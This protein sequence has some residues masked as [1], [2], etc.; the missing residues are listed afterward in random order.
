MTLAKTTRPST[1]GVLPRPRVFRLLDRAR[2]SPV[3]WISGPPGAGKTSAVAS[4]VKARRLP[5]LWYQLETGDGDV[6]SFFYY[7]RQ[8]A[9]AGPRGRAATLPLLT[10]EYLGGLESF[11]RRFFRELFARYR[12]PFVI[13]F[14][15]YQD[16]APSSQLHDVIREALG[17]IPPGGHVALISRG[18][19]PPTL[20]RLRAG[21]K[22]AL[23]G[24]P[25]LRLTEAEARRLVRTVAPAAAGAGFSALYDA[26]GGWAAGLVLMLEEQRGVS[27]A[28]GAASVASHEAIF[29]YFAGEIF[30]GAPVETREILLQTALLPRLTAAMAE[31]L[32]GR[33]AA[34]RVLAELSRQNYFTQ[35]HDGPEPVYQYHPLFREFLLRRAQVSLVATRRSEI[36][37]HGAALL[38]AAGQVEDAVAVL[39]DAREWDG[40]AALIEKEAPALVA[41][42]RGRTLQAWVDALPADLVQRRGWL[43]YWRGVCWFPFSPGASRAEFERALMH[44]WTQ[45][46]ATGTFLAWAAIVESFV[47]EQQDYHPLDRWIALLDDLVRDFPVFPSREVET[48][49]AL[50]ML[51]ALVA[52][53]PQ[54]PQLPQWAERATALAHAGPGHELRMQVTFHVAAYHLWRG[55]FAHA[56]VAAASLR[57]L[58]RMPDASPLPRLTAALGV[59]RVEW[60]TGGFAASRATVAD[61]R[62]LA[63]ATGVHVW[64]H[65]LMGDGVAAALCDGDRAGARRGLAELDA[66]SERLGTF[67]RAYHDFLLGW[68]ALLGGDLDLALRQHET[69]LAATRRM[70]M[71]AFDALAHF[72]A[73][74]VLAD[75]GA[76]DAAETHLN[77][78]LDVARSMQSRLF[79]FMGLL[80]AADFALRRDDV[81]A[82]RRSLAGALSLGRQR[83]YLNTWLWRPAMMA[84]LAAYA[85]EAGI[86]V[87]YARRLVIERRLVPDAAP[88]HLELWPWPVQVFTLG[89]FEL[90]R[91]GHSVKFS[92]KVQRRPLA[93]LEALIALGGENVREDR[94]AEALWPEADADAA[95]RA[96]ATTLH[97]L[98]RLIG[99]DEALRR[100]GGVVSLDPRVCWVDALAVDA[101]LARAE[102]GGDS[103]AV[104]AQAIALYRGDFVRGE[105]EVWALTFATRL[106]DR[107]MRQ[108]RRLAQYWEQM[109]QSDRAIDLYERGIGIDPV[110]E[111]LYRSLMVLHYRFGRKTDAQAVYERCRKNLA[112]TAGA[113][114]SPETEAIFLLQSA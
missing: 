38:Q 41:Q 6:A 103:V 102:A 110:A 43:L 26:V 7:L 1:R 35:R 28:A 76:L 53:Q 75:H 101:L 64:T 112:A 88:V 96:L 63:T 3:A 83:E 15:N 49:V 47:Y 4:Y 59:A 57:T 74:H 81:T 17:E 113:R 67:D 89:R 111:D 93:L 86:E 2:R 55:D 78:A 98:R 25:A 52:R 60:L 82:A 40:L 99:R 114:P 50:G 42:G 39:R 106:R 51:L 71:P 109:G 23:I 105:D 104:R 73:A 84:R 22:V 8:A 62:D 24:W 80:L 72:L 95:M 16:V 92:G 5:G 91:D 29:D 13:V 54:H 11:A 48:R 10:P 85:L 27:H 65:T 61:A 36:L 45:G 56:G 30:K 97:R 68:D 14:D 44:L 70:G 32:T 108:V 9:A 33:P 34:G 12:G 94:L 19:P 100:Q 21:Q 77:R 90:R 18:D 107:V 20:A 31:A 79:E 58:A 66:V 87:D 37:L 69:V 46:D